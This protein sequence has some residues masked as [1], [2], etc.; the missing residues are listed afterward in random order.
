[1]GEPP[2]SLVVKLQLEPGPRGE[3]LQVVYERRARHQHEDRLLGDVRQR[4]DVV[5]FRVER[6]GE[7]VAA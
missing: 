2:P 5:E 3:C 7:A 1:M 6:Q 4:S